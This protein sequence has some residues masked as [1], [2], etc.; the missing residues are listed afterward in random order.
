VHAT[1]EKSPEARVRESGRE[2]QRERE[3]PRERERES[4]GRNVFTIEKPF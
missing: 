3:R 1:I 4:L 2:Q